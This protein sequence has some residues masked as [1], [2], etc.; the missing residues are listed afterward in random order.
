[1]PNAAEPQVGSGS[2]AGYITDESAVA[3][4][5]AYVWAE[6]EGGA[7]WYGPSTASPDGS[8]LLSGLPPGAYRVF[9]SASGYPGEY[10]DGT[11]D[12]NAATLVN[13]T[14]GIVTPGIGFALALGGSISGTVTDESATPIA[15]AWVNASSVTCCGSGY[16]VT[17]ADGTYTITDLAPGSYVVQVYSASP[18]APEY[19]NGTYDYNVA[20]H[21]SV[22]SGLTA[23][24]ID[25]ALAIGGSITGTVTDGSSVPIAG[26][27]VEASGV[28]CCGGYGNTTTAADGTYTITGLLPG[29][30]RLSAVASGYASEYY[31]GTHDYNAATQVGVSLGM[32]ISDID[33][34]LELSGSI[35]GT[36]TDESATPIAGASVSASSDA[37]CCFSATTAADGSYTITGLAPGSYRVYASGAGHAGEYYDDTYDYNAA[38]QVTVTSGNTTPGI[39]LALA[40]GGII[41]GLVTDESSTPVAGVS[42]QASSL[43]CCGYGYATTA[44]DG[45]YTITDLPPGSYAVQA[46]GGGYVSEYYDNAMD[47][48]AAKPVTVT[49]GATTSGIDFALTLGGS[50]SGTITNTSAVPIQGASVQASGTACCSDGYATTAFDGTYTITGL[51]AGSYTIYAYAQGYPMKYYED[52]YDYGSAT[53]IDVASGVTTPGIDMALEPGG[54]VS[55][56]VTNGSATPIAGASVQATRTV[57]CGYGSATT[58]ADGTY[59]MTGL[60]PGTYTVQ[61]YYAASCPPSPPGGDCDV[62]APQYYDGVYDS[63]AATP[64]GVASGGTTPGIDF[65]LERGATISGTVADSSATPIAGASLN[66]TRSVCCGYGYGVTAADGTYVIAGLPPGSYVVE[67]TGSSCTVSPPTVLCNSYVPQY[68]DG[69]DDV[70]GATSIPLSADGAVGGINFELP[71]PSALHPLPIGVTFTELRD[72]SEATLHGGEAQPCGNVGATVWYRLDVPASPEGYPTI[73]VDTVGSDFDTAV[74]VYRADGPGSTPLSGSTLLSCDADGSQSMALFTTTSGDTY[75]IQVGGQDGATGTLDVNVSWDSAGDGYT[76]LMKS[77]LGVTPSIYCNIM[78]ADVNDSGKV[79]LSDLVL[80]AQQYNQKI[81]PAAP[82]YNQNGDA[83]ITLADLVL[84]AQVYNQPVTICDP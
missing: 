62:Y 81:P 14:S 41:S 36:V 37:I 17:A 12:F 78:R 73:S 1:M 40:A 67:A 68:Y 66:A 55:G 75:F 64:V 32:T 11:Y 53:P 20:T 15:G 60:A 61:V 80:T 70:T 13:V 18:H 52:T 10:Y 26:A 27:A 24:G 65:A 35:S 16:A 30:Y 76:D 57:C 47:Y 7:S 6:V 25:F 22:M 9:A 50:I 69:V 33:F 3:I 71:D 21:V 23:P 34:A 19:Y 39:D 51:A 49:S 46:S 42:V 56:T 5:G 77:R 43:T 54:T 8:Y 58:A 72:T 31:D 63:S 59:T 29:N 48:A 4:S 45:T 2:I 79:T 44:A 28:T 82:R 84:E 83:K 38:T 74:A